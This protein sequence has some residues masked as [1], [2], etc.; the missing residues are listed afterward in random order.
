M[1][2]LTEAPE[3]TARSVALIGGDGEPMI[4]LCYDGSAGAQA[5][6]AATRLLGVL[7]W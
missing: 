1:N 4:L 5:A 2:C 6:T 3:N 7:V